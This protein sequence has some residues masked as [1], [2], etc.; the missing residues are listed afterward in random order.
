MPS[1]SYA[2]IDQ[3]RRNK[4]EDKALKDIFIGYAFDSSAWLIYNP[5]TR[6]VTRTCSVTF[7][8]K[9]KSLATTLPPTIT[10]DYESDDDDIDVSGEHK[11]AAPQVGAQ[12]P[13]IPIPGEQQPPEPPLPKLH[14]PPTDKPMRRATQLL[15]DIEEARLRMEREPIGRA[16][17]R[18]ADARAAA[19]EVEPTQ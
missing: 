3:S 13:V 14:Q 1:L 18:R 11:S 4:F 9:L 17:N 7:D 5:T 8:E 10:N 12:D 15:K 2:H 6:R 16:E 19:Q